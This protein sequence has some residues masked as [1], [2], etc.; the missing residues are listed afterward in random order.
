MPGWLTDGMVAAATNSGLPWAGIETVP[1]DTQLANG[2]PPQTVSATLAQ[3]TATKGPVKALTDTGAGTKV[4]TADCS[5]N[6]D[7]S[8]T[9]TATGYT[10]TLANPNPG[11]SARVYVKQD[12]TGSR[13]ITTYTNVL[14]ASGT[15]PTL[16]A[17]AA[18]TDLLEFRYNATLGKWVGSSILN[19][20]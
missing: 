5:V 12:A 6:N 3:L 14:W 18:A 8:I 19:I 7:F 13:T 9:L 10:L 2:A 16:T 11:Q 17:T 4:L 20:S 15:A 1:V